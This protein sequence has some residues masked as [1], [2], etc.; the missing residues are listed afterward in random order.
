[1]PKRAQLTPKKLP[2]GNWQLNVP[3]NLSGTGSRSRPEYGSKQEALVE[4]KRLRG[5]IAKHGSGSTRFT[6]SEANDA[7]AAL[8]TLSEANFRENYDLTLKAAAR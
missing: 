8:S 6:S 1:M 4:A 7:Q 5:H 3:A 2:N